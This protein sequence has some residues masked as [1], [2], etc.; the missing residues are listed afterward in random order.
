MDNWRK[1]LVI[2]NNDKTK[3]LLAKARSKEMEVCVWGAGTIGSGFGKQILEKNGVHID[4]Y[5]DNE[6]GME[7][8]EVIPG[9]YCRSI[10]KL[11]KNKERTVCFILVGY[12]GVGVI[13]KQLIERGI[14]NIVT[15][16]DLL[17]L[18]DT[19]KRELPFLNRKD[20]AIYTCIIGGYDDIREPRYISDRC[21]YFLISDKSPENK[22]VYQWLDIKSY[23]PEGIEDPIYQ[24]RY[25][26][27]NAHKIFPQYRYSVY[28]DG[29]IT[30]VGDIAE[31]I[32]KLKKA[33]LGVLGNNYTDNI[34]EYALRCAKMG[35]DWSEKLMRQMES[36]WLQGLPE[37]SGSFACG[38]LL[39]EHN[40]PICVK[41]MEEWWQ[42]FCSYA[43]RDQ[44]PLTYV[45]W[46]NGFS[47]EDVLVLCDMEK[48]DPWDETPYWK[49][50]REH[51]K[52][53]FK[54]GKDV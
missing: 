37:N 19:M 33:R 13:Y 6:P 44:T 15:Y 32:N 25:C 49:Y 1:N 54:V 26:K 48:F 2:H 36:Y 34:F 53:R 24:N 52:E 17:A 35:A 3:E 22:S 28:V 12:A 46:K 14:K 8:A 40:N 38:I 43:K 51:K 50:E 47:K 42:E 23:L 11:I 31:N 16:D 18:P 10:D 20:T 9:V 39:R 21:D 30:I 45:L 4:Y 27:I 41:L 29:N 5:C 7:N